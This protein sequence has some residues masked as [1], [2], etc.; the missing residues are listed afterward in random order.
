LSSL[1]AG[2]IVIATTVAADPMTIVAI[3][4][5]TQSGVPLPARRARGAGGIAYDDD[6]P[7]SG[8][9]SGEST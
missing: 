4:P 8:G 3:T 9:T 5:I 1:L 6:P 2:R 7:E